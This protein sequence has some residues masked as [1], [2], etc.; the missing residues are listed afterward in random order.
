MLLQGSCA[1]AAVSH[2]PRSWLLSSICKWPLHNHS[3]REY[4]DDSSFSTYL[5]CS[6]VAAAVSAGQSDSVS[7]CIGCPG[8]S[9]S[10]CDSESSRSSSTCADAAPEM[11]VDPSEPIVRFTKPSVLC[12]CID[13]GNIEPWD[14]ILTLCAFAACRSR[15]NR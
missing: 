3:A 12:V 8:L 7:S 15:M 4:L 9:P 2:Q 13:E 14:P 11:M 6:G 1:R 5:L 10:S